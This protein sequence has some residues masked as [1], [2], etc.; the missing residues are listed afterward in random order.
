VS[1]LKDWFPFVYAR[2][3]SSIKDDI[4]HMLHVIDFQFVVTLSGFIIVLRPSR[5]N[6]AS[7]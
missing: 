6:L 1:A 7:T 5:C 3:R 2:R 4:C